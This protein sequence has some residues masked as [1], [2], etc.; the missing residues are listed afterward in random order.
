MQTIADS[1]PSPFSM[2]IGQG[3]L[4]IVQRLW[5]EGRV[6]ASVHGFPSLPNRLIHVARCGRVV[7]MEFVLEF[8]STMW[9]DEEKQTALLVAAAE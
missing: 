3:D 5:A 8:Y 2:A 4:A 7:L 9:I 6:K 1:V